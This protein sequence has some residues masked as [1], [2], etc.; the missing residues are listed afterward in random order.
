MMLSKIKGMMNGKLTSKQDWVILL[1]S[2][3][4]FA[5]LLKGL[6]F[7]DQYFF[8]QMTNKH[9]NFVSKFWHKIQNYLL[10]NFEKIGIYCLAFFKYP[11]TVDYLAK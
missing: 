10:R 11:L 3:S 5:S 1:D 9:L 6:I 7:K 2:Q 8:S 4:K